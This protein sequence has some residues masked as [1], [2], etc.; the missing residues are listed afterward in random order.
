MLLLCSNNL[1]GC[2]HLCMT[3][4]RGEVR[5]NKASS[6]I[7]LKLFFKESK[8]A[9]LKLSYFTK[10]SFHSILGYIY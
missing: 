5:S 8:F 3:N 1:W 10:L 2:S 9:R 4:T 7:A 6:Q